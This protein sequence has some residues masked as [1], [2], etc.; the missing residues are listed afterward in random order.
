MFLISAISRSSSIS[1]YNQELPACSRLDLHPILHQSLVEDGYDLTSSN[2][3]CSREV[4]SRY[5]FY[6]SIILLVN[7]CESSFSLAHGHC[8]T[9]AIA[10]RVV[11]PRDPMWCGRHTA[12]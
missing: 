5:L 4:E 9:P 11:Y 1:I 12:D 3:L 8:E 2:H 6:E 7:Q 10:S